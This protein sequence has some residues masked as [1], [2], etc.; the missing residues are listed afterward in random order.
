MSKRAHSLSK[1]ALLVFKGSK[2]R[3]RRVTRGDWSRY[4]GLVVDGTSGGV[5]I[6]NDSLEF[7][8]SRASLINQKFAIQY[9]DELVANALGAL[10]VTRIVDVG[11]DFGSLLFAGANAG[12]VGIGLDPSQEA[13]TLCQGAGLAAVQG[14]YQALSDEK[15]PVRKEIENFLGGTTG[16]TAV[17]LLNILHMAKKR[18]PLWLS[19][20]QSWPPS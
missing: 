6:S 4:D 5:S 1:K 12:I 3:D 19:I 8:V 15:S 2:V 7:S 11:C 10:S 13:I 17:T 9:R 14:G 18:S 16:K 20:A